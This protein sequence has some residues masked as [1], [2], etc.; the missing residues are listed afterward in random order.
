MREQYLDFYFP[1][2]SIKPTKCPVCWPLVSHDVQEPSFSVMAE[3]YDRTVVPFPARDSEIEMPTSVCI[4]R[5]GD[6]SCDEISVERENER[7]ALDLVDVG[8]Q[9]RRPEQ[10]HGFF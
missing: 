7:L 6:C 3:T 10:G 1:W 5:R 2:L 8:R 4:I 9:V